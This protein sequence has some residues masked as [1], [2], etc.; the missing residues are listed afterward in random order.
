VLVASLGL[1]GCTVLDKLAQA[2]A[3]TAGIDKPRPSAP[4]W[5]TVT[6]TAS[7]DANQNSP[8]AIDLVFVRDAAL[9]QT[10]TATP[11]AK[12]FATR[13]DT[14]RAFP[15]TLGVVSLEVVPGQ[16]LRLTD[17]A[18]IGQ[19]ALVI[20]AFANYP[21]PGEHRERLLPT[22]ADYLVQLGPKGFK[23]VDVHAHPPK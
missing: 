9:A 21:P 1:G 20:L 5:Q 13:A 2:V 15:D 4:A 8:V 22:G 10:L 3:L 19:R 12:W 11:A 7:A 17:A 23:G 6:L 14:L 18:T 16:T